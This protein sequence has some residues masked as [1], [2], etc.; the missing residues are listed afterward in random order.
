MDA[1]DMAQIAS[2]RHGATL[3]ADPIIS[4]GAAERAIYHKRTVDLKLTLVDGHV[5]IGHQHLEKICSELVD[6]GFKFSKAGDQ[7]EVSGTTTGV[8]Y[9][10]AVKDKGKGM[11][12]EDIGM[13]LA[14]LY[15]RSKSLGL[16]MYPRREESY[17]LDITALVTSMATR[18]GLRGRF[19]IE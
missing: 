14:K 16:R 3:A 11:T 17:L 18:F 7:V 1:N 12:A 13:I 2:M 9:C 5:A 10:L 4:K 19:D 15:D 6:N 8:M